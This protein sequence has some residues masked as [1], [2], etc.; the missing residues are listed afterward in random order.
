LNCNKTDECTAST[1]GEFGNPVRQITASPKPTA[2]FS[3]SKGAQKNGDDDD[4]PTF[5]MCITSTQVMYNGHDQRVSIVRKKSSL[6]VSKEI[7]NQTMDFY[8]F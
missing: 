8:I 3:V 6:I 7:S 1:A 2:S 5:K 4:L